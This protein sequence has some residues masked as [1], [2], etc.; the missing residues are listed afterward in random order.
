M[1]HDHPIEYTSGQALLVHGPEVLHQHYSSRVEKAMGKAMPQMEV[2]VK[3]LSLSTQVS[4]PSDG[5][6]H[7][8]PTVFNEIKTGVR[9]LF[10]GNKNKITKHIL[11]NISGVFKPGTMTLVLGQPGSG[12]SSLL[13]M[14]SG[15]FPL[16]KDI[17]LEGDVTY[18]GLDRIEIARRLPQFATYVTQRDSHFPTLTVKETLEFA[19][20]CCGAELTERDERHFTEGTPEENKMALDAARALYKHYPEVVIQQ[21]GLETCQDTIVGDEM[22]RGVSGGE[23]KR[24]TTGEMEF[25]N[26]YAMFMDEIST[27]LDSAATIDIIKTQRSIAQT[28]RKTIVM[29]LLQP[30]PEVFAL[31]D[32]VIILNKGRVMYQGPCSDVE[33]YFRALGFAC[34]PSR[35]VADFLLDLGTHQQ[36]QY[37]VEREGYGKH[38]RTAREFADAF[39]QSIHYQQIHEA[40]AQPHDPRLLQDVSDHFDHVPEFHQSFWA[41][42]WTLSKREIK[43]TWRNTAFITGRALLV[44][45]IGFIYSSLFYQFDV[46]DVQVVMGT[47]FPAILFFALGQSTQIPLYLDA[48]EVF[49]K[50]RGANFYRTSS[51]VVASSV[52]QVPIALIETIIY[53]SLVYW[54]CGFASDATAFVVFEVVLFVTNLAFAAWFFFISVASPSVHVAEPLGMLSLLLYILFAGFMITKDSIPVYFIWAYWINPMSWAFRSL[55]INQFRRPEFQVCEYDGVDYCSLYGKQMDIFSLETFDI[56][57]EKHWL[58]YGIIFMVGMYF[59]FMALVGYVLEHVRYESPE[60]VTADVEEEIATSTNSRTGNSDESAYGLV[61]TPREETAIPVNKATFEGHFEPVTLAFK[62]LWYSVPDPKN[63]KTGTLDLLKGVSGFATPGTITALMGS[64]GAGKTTLMDVIAGRKTG[65]KSRG[66]I[67]LN[68]HP[69]SDLA[70]RRATGYCEQMDIHSEASTIREAL[71]F[72]AFLR[73]GSDVPDSQKYDSVEECL[74]LLDL[75]PIADQIIRGSSVEQMKRLTIGVE[76][77]AQPSV[78]FLDEP[79]SGLDAR[80]AKVIMDGVRKVADTGRTVVCTIHQPSW[81]VFSVFDSLLLLKR[82]GQTVFF[83][84]VGEKAAEV[85]K[86][87]E[88]IEGV[89]PLEEGYNPATWMLEVIGAGVGNTANADTDFVAMF[90]SSEKKALLDESL[91]RP[92]MCTP[93]PGVAA[94]AFKSK[95]AASSWTQARFLCKRFVNLYWRSAE[96]NLTRFVISILLALVF[97]LAYA[98]TE[99]KTYKGI[100]AGVGMVFSAV[101]FVGVVAFDSVIPITV[102]DRRA[103]YRERASETY[104]AFWYF[105]GATLI[106]IPYVFASMFCF[107]AIFYPLV[108]LTMD[109][110]FVFF[111]FNLSL[112]VLLMTYM[113]QFLSYALPSVE[114]AAVIGVLLTSIFFIFMG[115]NPPASAIPAGY[116]WLHQIAPPTYTMA[117]LSAIEFGDCPGDDPSE[118]GCHQLTDVP[119]TVPANV[120]VK[121]YVDEIFGID[122]D[123]L[124]TNFAVIVGYILLFRVLALLSLRFISHQ[125][126]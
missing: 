4:V 46:K 97:G 122:H 90:E 23:R 67:L 77:A 39:E 64:S 40:V 41:S 108:G 102:E 109:G 80:S 32:D 24:V 121:A 60:H 13:K 69:A 47:I 44:L 61:E 6:K 73:Q 71:T 98:D 15:R 99:Y 93:A 82:G 85:V 94:L 66:E 74:D 12:K 55:A 78:L 59:V 27:G 21:L 25:G 106:E 112:H 31:F 101:V 38:P 68:G 83:G 3:N 96:Y 51:Y 76:L 113:G 53:G 104:N 91:A 65:G 114:V 118:I 84:D 87:F 17:Q 29:A 28:L 125:K 107:T 1:E 110:R 100:N 88:S 43:V 37:E 75:R 58:L 105:V 116:K 45:I 5:G 89:T 70:I 26:R 22:L 63:P 42:T 35:D 117:V 103:F 95:R 49:Y 124:W 79:T 119:P 20:A 57:T 92:G 111:W 54:F 56:D 62:D 123:E 72:S 7:E 2:R 10:A 120:T 48:R 34:P 18:N 33:S 126:K 86:Y 36:S 19:H 9:D 52:S 14:L 30:S 81:E 11:K 115:Y 50:Q 16:T 8:L